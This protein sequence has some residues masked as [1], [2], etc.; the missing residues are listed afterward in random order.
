MRQGVA[1]G[2]EY[3]QPLVQAADPQDLR[4]QRLRRDEPIAAPR[5][6]GAAGDLDQ[7]AEPTDVTERQA[8][9]VEQQ[10]PGLAGD[11]GVALC[12]QAAG[13]GDIQLLRRVQDLDP[14]A[15]TVII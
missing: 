14:V 8:G 2:R 4:H 12:G 9:Q 6:V 13:G 5:L 15:A 1:D 7:G 11:G 3:W 10:Q